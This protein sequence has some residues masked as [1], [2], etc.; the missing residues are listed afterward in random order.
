MKTLLKKAALLASP[1]ALL[2]VCNLS[3]QWTLIEDFESYAAGVY[4]AEDESLVYPVASNGG[5]G[6]MDIIEGIEGTGGSNAAWFWYGVQLANAGDVWHQIPLPTPIEENQT[7]TISFRVWQQSYDGSWLVMVS[8]VGAGEEP[9][10]TALWGNQAAIARFSGNEPLMIDA[11]NGGSYTPS[12]PVFLPELASWYQYWYVLDNSYDA[13]GNQ[14]G[15]GGYSVYVQGPNDAEPQLLSWGGD[16]TV[17]DLDFRNQAQ[18]SLKTLVLIQ[19]AEK[20]PGI[21]L[22]DDIYMTSGMNLSDPTDPNAV[23]QWCDLDKVGGDVDTGDFLG[24]VYVGD[25]TGSGWVYSYSLGGFVYI[26]ACPGDSGAW[27]Y[28]LN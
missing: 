6:E 15:V 25:L 9:D 19:N 24:W 22:I 18:T 12:N 5:L 7:A 4:S 16:Q 26:S 27:V 3:A 14:A 17:T 21:W 1:L 2:P 23:S 13:E 11:R 20:S 10:N 8:K 28:V